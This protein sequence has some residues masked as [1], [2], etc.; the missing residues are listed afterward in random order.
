MHQEISLPTKKAVI[1]SVV[2]EK[3]SPNDMAKKMTV[4]N[5]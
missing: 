2:P 1:A 4:D 3:N 5:E